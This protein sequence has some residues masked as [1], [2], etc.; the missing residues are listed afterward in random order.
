MFVTSS[1]F[2]SESSLINEAMRNKPVLNFAPCPQTHL[3]AVNKKSLILLHQIL[4]IP[5]EE[6]FFRMLKLCVCSS[7]VLLAMMIILST[8]LIKHHSRSQQ[9]SSNWI[10]TESD[11]VSSLNGKQSLPRAQ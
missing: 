3:D 4:T 6:I 2:C 1:M 8:T 10:K 5:G 7:S 11:K 9:L